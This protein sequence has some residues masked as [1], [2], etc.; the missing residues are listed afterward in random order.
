[1]KKKMARN[2]IYDLRKPP[3][4]VFMSRKMAERLRRS[5]AK[6]RRIPLRM[7]KVTRIRFGYMVTAPS[8]YRKR[9]LV[10]D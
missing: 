9:R 6:E 8:K 1:V 2:K 10:Y 5:I 3:L 7:V 4:Q